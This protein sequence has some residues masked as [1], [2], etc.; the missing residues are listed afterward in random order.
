MKGPFEAWRRN[1]PLWA[2]PLGFCLLNLLGLA[3]YRFSY[4]GEVER[5]VDRRQQGEKTLAALRTESEEI[6]VFLVR[7]E[8]QDAAVERLYSEHFKSPAERLTDVF[9][10]ARRL[11]RNAGLHPT[12]FSYPQQTLEGRDG[13]VL[14]NIR[15]G[16][17]GSYRQMRT[18]INFLE[19]TDHFLTL[20]SIS[21]SEAGPD[22][23]SLQFQLST[24]FA[25]GQ[26]QQPSSEEAGS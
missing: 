15:F 16:V 17:Q 23:L 3:I 5:L 25:S 22:L 13:L 14:Q 7:V 2:I 6:D 12:S 19:L 26:R 24:V 21:L 1:L 11:A 10:E 20:N 8:A 9:G 18:F 4:S